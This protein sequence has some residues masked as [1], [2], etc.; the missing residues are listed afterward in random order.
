MLWWDLDNSVKKSGQKFLQNYVRDWLCLTENKELQ[1]CAAK[2]ISTSYWIMPC[3]KWC[4]QM[5]GVYFIL[6]KKKVFSSIKIKT[7]LSCRYTKYTKLLCCTC[8]THTCTGSHSHGDRCHIHWSGGQPFTAPPGTGMAPCSRAPQPWLQ[9]SVHQSL[10]SEN[11]TTNLQVTGRPTLASEP[12]P[13]TAE[14]VSLGL[15]I[16]LFCFPKMGTFS[17][18]CK[19]SCKNCEILRNK[20]W[21]QYNIQITRNSNKKALFFF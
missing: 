1:V 13:P 2:N 10:S 15:G 7:L 20:V 3:N 5:F 11:W 12:R 16:V 6:G 14:A 8:W 21:H 18:N 17:S 4:K 19:L 9:L